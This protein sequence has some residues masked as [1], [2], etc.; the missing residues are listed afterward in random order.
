MEKERRNLLRKRKGRK[1]KETK[2]NVCEG[3]IN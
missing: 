1:N 2:D 3:F